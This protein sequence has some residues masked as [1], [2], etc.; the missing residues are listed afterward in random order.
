M[1]NNA[2]NHFTSCAN[3]DDMICGLVLAGGEGARLQ[4]FIKSLGKGSLPK[5]YVNFVGNQSM[6]EHTWQRAQK[7]IPPEC[8][9]TVISEAHLRHP[10]VRQQFSDRAPDTLIIQPENRETGPGLLLPLMHLYKRHPNSV[11]LVLPSDHFVLEE[12]RLMAQAH[13]ACLAVKRDPSRL[14]LLGVK[15]D[16]EEPDYGYILPGK[17]TALIQADM[18][19]ISLFIEKPDPRTARHLIQ[20]GGLWNT[21]IMAFKTTSMLDWVSRCAPGLYQEFQQIYQAIGTPAEADLVRDTYRRLQPVNF[22]KELLEPL[23]R[24]YPSSLVALRV[25][26]VLWS[27]WGTASRVI[28]I[29]RKIG[30]IGQLNGFRNRAE[31]TVQNLTTLRF[32]DRDVQPVFNQ[33][34]AIPAARGSRYE[35]GPRK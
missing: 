26:D 15:P 20:G 17:K 5:Q 8:I 9:F 23:V 13:L 30:S 12:D 4:P 16:R 18:S 35:E 22:S 7:L 14:V 6:L 10:E 11:V 21:M 24:H 31:K 28:D 1:N 2:R 25:R 33:N 27:D 32:N 19:E 3:P 34:T 29:L